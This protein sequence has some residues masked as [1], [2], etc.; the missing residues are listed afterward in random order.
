MKTRL[1][2]T[3]LIILTLLTCFAAF[4]SATAPA[5]A[6]NQVP[7]KGTVSGEIPADMGLPVPGSGGCVFNFF[8]SNHG[9]ATHVGAFTGTSNP[10]RTSAMG[11]TLAPLTG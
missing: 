7:F 1:Q 5:L 9:N 10:S 2:L 11:A 4:F 6:S 3:N 8:V